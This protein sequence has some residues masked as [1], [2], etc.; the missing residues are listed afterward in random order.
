MT[1]LALTAFTATS[2]LGRGLAATLAALEARRGG[3]GP[4][5]FETVALETCVGEVPGVD[6]ARLP[7]ELRRV[8][9]PQ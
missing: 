9:M 5:A 4:C 2:C 1:P 7:P 3:L 8:R 6:D